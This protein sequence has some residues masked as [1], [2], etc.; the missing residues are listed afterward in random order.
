MLFPIG[1]EKNTVTRLPIVTALLILTNI[2]VFLFTTSQINND[3]PQNDIVTVKIHILIL[4]A[5]YPD[6]VASPE[7]QQMIDEFRKAKP[8]GWTWLSANDRKPEDAWEVALLLDPEPRMDKLQ[9]QMDELCRK[10]STLQKSDDS[11]LWKYA[12]HSYKPTPESYITHQFLHGG[13]LH[14]IGNMWMLWLCGFVLEDVW[15][16]FVVLAFYLIA[17]IAAASFHG[18]MT[19]GSVTPMLGASGSIAGLMGAMLARFPTLKIRFIYFWILPPKM[20]TF[21]VPVFIVAPLWLLVEVFWGLMGE[22]GVAHWAHVGGFIFGVIVGLAFY[23]VKLEKVVNREDPDKTWTPDPQYLH[24][25]E[26]LDDRRDPDGCIA[27]LRPFLKQ[28]PNAIEGWQLLMR[29]QDWRGDHA[30]ERDETLPQLIRLSFAT[31]DAGQ[32]KQYIDQYRSIGGTQLPAA[33]WIEL[34]RNYE[35]DQLWD[36]AA[37]EYEQ[38]GQTY[39]ATDRVSLTALMSGARIYLSKLNRPTDAERLFRAAQNSPI[40]HLDVDGMIT[41]GLKECAA[42]QAAESKPAGA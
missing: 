17:G 33:T 19:P 7:A 1:H 8:A 24:A 18:W 31:G 20:W 39:Y 35:K 23:A 42:A 14:L 41:Q 32:A 13:W 16:P 36:A 29:A 3:N 21:G 26:L 38:L 6:L 22:A 10:W 27:V 5:R 37:R 11:L 15:G 2:L 30:A 25:V 4:K 9:E 40:P 12:Y 28:K 34:C